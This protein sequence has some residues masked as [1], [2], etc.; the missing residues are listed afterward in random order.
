[1]RWRADD[2]G[3]RAGGDLRGGRQDGDDVLTRRV[4]LRKG[5]HGG[6][7]LGA[8]GDCRPRRVRVSR[9]GSRGAGGGCRGVWL[10][11]GVGELMGREV[12]DAVGTRA[13]Q[14]AQHVQALVLTPV[15]VQAEDGG[16]DQQHHCKIEHNHDGR[17]RGGAEEGE[18]WGKS[19]RITDTMSQLGFI[20]AS[21]SS[22]AS[23]FPIVTPPDASK[24]KKSSSPK[25]PGRNA[26]QSKPF[27]AKLLP[28]IY[29]SS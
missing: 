7:D 10:L 26:K 5:L 1:M 17:L 20:S 16:E 21:S 11:P 23:F 18:C 9:S 12:D 24:V 8:G 6:G 14:A 2:D 19:S 29:N 15:E 22:S 25:S 13:V 3:C 4:A 27:C 28:F